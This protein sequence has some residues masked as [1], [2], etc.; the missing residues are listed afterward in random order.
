MKKIF[1][2]FMLS[3]LIGTGNSWAQVVIG[4]S[5]NILK[6]VAVGPS[7]NIYATSQGGQGV[8]IINGTDE[9][10]KIFGQNGTA[11]GQFANGSPAG[12]ALDAAEKIYVADRG[13]NRIQVFDK[14]GN[15]L[16]AH[17]VGSFPNGI[18]IDGSGKIC[19]VEEGNHGFK[20]FN[21]SFGLIKS[22]G[23][24]VGSGNGQFNSPDGVSFDQFGNF[25]IADR[26]NF[27]IQKFNTA[28]DF[29]LAFGTSGTL[30]GQFSEP[31]SVKVYNSEVYVS[32]ATNRLQ[33]FDLNGVWKRK[34]T[35]PAEGNYFGIAFTAT[36][37]LVLASSGSERIA[38][39]N[40]AGTLLK[41]YGSK[42]SADGGLNYPSG[43]A[44]LSNGDIVTSELTA[45]SRI[46][47]FTSTGVFKSKFNV[48]G[49]IVD[50]DVH[51]QN[52]NIYVLTMT[53][54]KVHRFSSSGVFLA[55]INIPD[56]TSA[57]RMSID[58]D[59][60]IWLLLATAP[61]VKK[62][63]GNT[64]GAGVGVASPLLQFGMLGN[65]DGQFGIYLGDIAIDQVTNNVYVAAGSATNNGKIQVF[66]NN[67]GAHKLTWPELHHTL[68]AIDGTSL[69]SWE[70]DNTCLVK[71]FSLNNVTLAHTLLNTTSGRGLSIGLNSGLNDLDFDVASGQLGM[72]D[73]FNNRVQVLT[74][75]PEIAVAQAGTNIAYG[76]TYDV[77]GLAV[78]TPKQ[79]SFTISSQG[80]Q[81]IML[82][83]T[84]KVS[85]AG[86][87]A[88]DFVI[89]QT[90]LN[91][92]I[93]GNSSFKIIFTP[94]ATGTRTATIT[95]PN[96]DVDEGPFTFTITGKG[97]T[98]QTIDNFTSLPVKMF[99]DA[100]FN[101]TATSSSGLPV[102]YQSTNPSVATIVG[103]IVTITGAGITTITATQVGNDSFFEVSKSLIFTVNKSNQVITFA[104]LADKTVGDAA[105][106]L[107]AT[108]SS[109]L[110]VNFS[111]TSDRISIMGSQVTIVKAGRA[112]ITA[113]QIGNANYNAATSMD[114]SFC[115]KPPKPTVTL[116]NS[117][118]ESPT[119]TSS[120]TS[121]N[122]WFLNG[123][124][125]SGATN[126]TYN[127]TA[128]G[129][130]KVQVKVDDCVSE[131]SLDQALIV[132][133]D[134]A[135]TNSPALHAYPNPTRDYLVIEGISHQVQGKVTNLLGANQTI[136]QEVKGE[137]LL[138][139]VSE[140]TPGVYVLQVQEPNQTRTLRF[141]KE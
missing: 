79:F 61:M 39:Y 115:I 64:T 73:Y 56:I 101:L 67:T 134:I 41:S 2:L 88:S 104:A 93:T 48:A 22:V 124:A 136:R 87:N 29:V 55:S 121:G 47:I 118:T 50:V 38:I 20:L 62:Y 141:I 9:S 23:G 54:K 76:S 19:V 3:L 94:S 75:A 26:S 86:S 10:V 24:A 77:G 111:S 72:S 130:Y 112:T 120:A 140:L 40:P 60:N 1:L 114:R 100:N 5:F 8:V 12:I 14:N 28:G 103:N 133:G 68:I 81:P 95:I 25:F 122:Q 110:T 42:S 113:A 18:D 108:S 139:Y 105:F 45:N 90:D 66:D 44:R 135:V 65:L 74:L 89:D 71:H 85:I 127:A 138:I 102:T 69:I 4:G 43:V 116:S 96:N 6:S 98:N 59:G 123:A 7:G 11:N 17:A 106:D 51:K 117:N 91:A 31:T 37:N 63:D 32:D 132:T 27:R 53:D 119:L 92:T 58:K 21:S 82:S 131:F 109:N 49:N 83:G 46:Q 126:A 70:S 125:I 35:Y 78:N 33:V 16:S 128:A 52:N 13:N 97:K 30:D 15:F 129:V 34:A 80:I 36:G 137:R 99:G 57:T 107:S 84:P